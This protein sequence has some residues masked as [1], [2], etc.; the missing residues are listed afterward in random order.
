MFP[1]RLTII[2]TLRMNGTT[3]K[4]VNVETNVPVIHL[5]DG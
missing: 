2:N 3:H 4:R 5:I 1:F